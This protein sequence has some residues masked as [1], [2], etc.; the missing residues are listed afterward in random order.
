M[1]LRVWA[2][3]GCFNSVSIRYAKEIVYHKRRNAVECV[4]K[5]LFLP[6]KFRACL[7]AERINRGQDDRYADTKYQSGF[8]RT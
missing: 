1:I 7:Y 5:T 8:D 3:V 4:H 6:S 2:T